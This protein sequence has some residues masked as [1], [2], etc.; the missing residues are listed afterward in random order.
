M[1]TVLICDSD[2]KCVLFYWCNLRG[3]CFKIWLYGCLILFI[4]TKHTLHIGCI[5]SMLYNSTSDTCYRWT[6]FEQTHIIVLF[7]FGFFFLKKPTKIG[8][9]IFHSAFKH[10]LWLRLHPLIFLYYSL[11]VLWTSIFFP[12]C[13]YVAF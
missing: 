6:I 9:N 2:S 8:Y 12:F 11:S 13:I 5:I 3:L 1:Q 10:T 7:L 4:L